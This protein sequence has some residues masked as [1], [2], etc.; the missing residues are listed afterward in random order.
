MVEKS[1]GKEDQSTRIFLIVSI[2]QALSFILIFIIA[3][4]RL[5]LQE[6]GGYYGIGTLIFLGVYLPS[7]LLLIPDIILIKRSFKLSAKG[8][9]RGYIFHVL[10]FLWSIFLLRIPFM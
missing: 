3:F 1:N 8:R 6:G 2:F 9:L 5:I 4:M 7:L 10:A